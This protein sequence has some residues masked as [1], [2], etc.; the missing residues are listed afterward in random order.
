MFGKNTKKKP[1]SSKDGFPNT[2]EH[3][4]GLKGQ[5]LHR[6]A[7]GKRG[8]GCSPLQE[9]VVSLRCVPYILFFN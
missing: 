4:K 8:L 1:H 3:K 2:T 9:I 5:K 7:K 6:M